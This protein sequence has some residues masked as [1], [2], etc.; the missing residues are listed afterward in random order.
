MIIAAE[1]ISHFYNNRPVLDHVSL[2]LNKGE[3]ITII[4]P[5]GAGKS[6][7]LKCLMGL[8]TPDQGRVTRKAGSRIGYI[9]QRMAINPSLPMT[10]ARFIALN[11]S[12]P[13]Q[14]WD[15]LGIAGLADKPIHSL[16]GG[17]WQRVLLARALRDDPE[18]IIL[19][20]PAQNLDISGQLQFYK[21]LDAIHKSRGIAILMVSHDLHMVMAS[22]Q[23]VVCLYHHI[24]CSGAPQ[25]VAR[26]PEF[27]HLFGQDMAA[28][29]AIYQHEHN[30]DHDH[31]FDHHHH[32]HGG[33]H[34]HPHG[35]HDHGG[36]DHG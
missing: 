11:K 13:T 20:E 33:H 5:N 12:S 1:N 17:E 31:G 16:S 18:A 21:T 9:P 22:T 23:Q 36:H 10:V 7:L 14:D 4:G 19:D 26:D 24:C 27:A 15:D 29:M 2:S 32:P 34:D 6:T 35:G 8:I 30:H 3:F 28:M 25:T